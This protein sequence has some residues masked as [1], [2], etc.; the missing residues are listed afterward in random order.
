MKPRKTTTSYQQSYRQ[1]TTQYGVSHE[2]ANFPALVQKDGKWEVRQVSIE[3]KPFDTQASMEVTP[4]ERKVT[5]GARDHNAQQRRE[6]MQEFKQRR[7]FD[8][9]KDDG[10]HVKRTVNN[11][12][13]NKL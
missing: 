11:Q 10:T 7:S 13:R 12:W 9:V 4:L 8:D 2:E 6:I 1:E 3:E 5:L